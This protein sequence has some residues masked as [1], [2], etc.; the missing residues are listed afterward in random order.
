MGIRKEILCL[1]SVTA[2]FLMQCSSSKELEPAD[3]QQQRTDEEVFNES[4]LDIRDGDIPL[5][6]SV[7]HGG[8]ISPE[9]L[10]D[11]ECGTTVQDNNTTLLAFEIEKQLQQFDKN[12]YLIVGQI[13]RTKIDLNRDMEVATCGNS[14]MNETWNQYHA[15]IEKALSSAVEE[16]GYAVYIDLHGQSHPIR[17]LELGYL[18]SKSEL[19]QSYTE[20]ESNADLAEESSL[21]NFFTENRELSL[22]DMLTGE[23]ALGTIIEN[24]GYR[25]VPSLQDPF[26]ESDDP[27]FTGGYNTRR[28]TSSDYPEVF[29]LQIEVNF[30]GVR[31]SEENLTKFSEAFAPSI[32]EYLDFIEKQTN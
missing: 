11:R 14:I 22:K 29:G 27:Y 9:G 21:Y 17:R 3:G 2:L 16:F 15:N 5:V 7:P 26:P 20:E 8:E 30:V 19:Q 13:A 18:L 10:P 24:A 31:D 4:W 25:S 23:N 28:Y 12:P 6:I 32:L 1:L